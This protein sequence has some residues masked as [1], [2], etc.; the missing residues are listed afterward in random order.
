V[1]VDIWTS[2]PEMADAGKS[3]DRRPGARP[4]GSYS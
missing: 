4:R 2:G 3:M 1:L